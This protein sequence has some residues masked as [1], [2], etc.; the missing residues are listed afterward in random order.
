MVDFKDTL[1]KKFNDFPKRAVT[2]KLMPS[3]KNN[4]EDYDNNIPKQAS[5]KTNEEFNVKRINKKANNASS[6]NFNN[7][8][9]FQK[10]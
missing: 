9:K 10:S 7:K 8:E 6:T 5:L 2:V 4:I 1:N 3:N